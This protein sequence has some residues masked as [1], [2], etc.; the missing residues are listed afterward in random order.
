MSAAAYLSDPLQST[1]TATLA[2]V[3]PKQVSVFVSNRGP[4]AAVF[5]PHALCS[6]WATEKAETLQI[7][8]GSKYH[9]SRYPKPTE[10]A[11]R[12]IYLY[13]DDEGSAKISEPGKREVFK[14]DFRDLLVVGDKNLPAGRDEIKSYCTISYKHEK[15]TRRR[16]V[17]DRGQ[18]ECYVLF[19]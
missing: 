11:G 5:Q 4:G 7:G 10:V 19:T 15:R 18:R 14:L 8:D 12:Y 1:F 9:A 13:G 3:S 16:P 2:E 6:I 17:A